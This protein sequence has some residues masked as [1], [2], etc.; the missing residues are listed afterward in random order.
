MADVSPFEAVKTI[1]NKQRLTEEE[2]SGCSKW[3]LNKIM[4]CDKQLGLIANEL[5]NEFVTP[6][7]VYDCYF[8]GLAPVPNKYIP[9]NAKKAAV[10][11]EMR[12]IMEFYQVNQNVAKQYQKLIS[13]EEKQTVIDF[14]EKRGTKKK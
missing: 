10:E 6:K 4:S 2:I 9:Y 11:K 3:M 13:P 12:Y 7:M 8:Y 1:F 5:N 14:F